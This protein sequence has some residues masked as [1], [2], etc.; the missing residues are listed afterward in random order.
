MNRISEFSTLYQNV[1]CC[2][3]I[4]INKCKTRLEHSYQIKR[5]FLLNNF[6]KPRMIYYGS[7]LK[8]YVIAS[9][10]WVLLHLEVVCGETEWLE[11]HVSE[12]LEAVHHLGLHLL[13]AF[14]NLINMTGLDIQPLITCKYI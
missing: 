2:L 5:Y 6:T 14:L 7:L 10:V 8:F 3:R 12:L 1:L 9:G 11:D 4:K 13:V